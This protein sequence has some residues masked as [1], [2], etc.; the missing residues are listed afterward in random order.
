MAAKIQQRNEVVD[1]QTAEIYNRIVA[2]DGKAC[3]LKGQAMNALYGSLKGLRQ[4]GDIDIWMMDEPLKVIE[5]ARKTGKM[6]YYDYHHADISIFNDTEVEVH[7]RPSISRNLVRNARLQ[8]W[9]RE[10]GAKHIV[11]PSLDGAE[12]SINHKPLPYNL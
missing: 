4:S 12:V 2:D 8:K 7:Y 11:V 9:F 10:V 5:W 3:V 6:Y 1:R